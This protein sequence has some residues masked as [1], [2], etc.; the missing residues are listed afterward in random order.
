[1]EQSEQVSSD[2]VGRAQKAARGKGRGSKFLVLDRDF[3]EVL[4]CAETCNRL[5]FIMTAIVLL[6]GT[7]ADHRLTKWS[8]KSVEQYTGI[9]KPR[10]KRAIEELER[11]NILRHTDHS[12]RIAPQYEFQMLPKMADGEEDPI[13]L[14]VEL[15]T[16]LAGETSMLRRLREIGD[17]MALVMLIDLYSLIEL[18]ATYGVGMDHCWVRTSDG[19]ASGRKIAEVGVHALWAMTMGSTRQVRGEWTAKHR[20][21]ENDWSRFWETFDSLEKAGAFI[22]EPW[23]VDGETTSAEPLY[24]VDP[25][26]IYGHD[27]GDRVA[28][29]TSEAF[30]ACESLLPDRE[31]VLNRYSYDCV[32][33]FPLHHQTPA[34][35]GILKL[36]IEPDTPGRRRSFAKRME[37]IERHQSAYSKLRRNAARGEY[38]RPLNFSHVRDKKE[39]VGD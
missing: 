3:W 38:G 30:L 25:A 14:P 34:C 17:A 12:T 32:A 33:P 4:Q 1:M 22:F 19:E 11:A 24:P 39:P 28:K 26:V 18:D 8:A 29:I 6:A 13:F 31:E 27:T 15:V 35:R 5:N 7:G 23:V 2:D 37:A 10:A 9:G 20:I 21:G 16:G 36:R